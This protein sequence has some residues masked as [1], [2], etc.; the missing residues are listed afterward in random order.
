MLYVVA[1][2]RG[3]ISMII[4]SVFNFGGPYI[5]L[6][7]M[8]L[9]VFSGGLTIYLYHYNSF[10]KRK[11][12]NFFGIGVIRNRIKTKSAD[13]GLKKAIL[14]FFAGFFDFFEYILVAFYVPLIAKMSIASD[15]RLGCVSTITSALVCIYA[16][17]FKVGKHHKFSLIGLS[18]CLC[19]IFNN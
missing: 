4:G 11:V 10:R 13:G 8:A 9:G 19:L 2:I 5:F 15:S 12:I 17:R 3:I 14:I 1:F 18:I 16:L 7:L 6:F